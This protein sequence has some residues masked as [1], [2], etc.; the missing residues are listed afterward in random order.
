MSG[1]IGMHI[2]LLPN[3]IAI[4]NVGVLYIQKKK[5]TVPCI[6]FF[7]KTNEQLVSK[8]VVVPE[9]GRISVSSSCIELFKNS[10]PKRE[11]YFTFLAALDIKKSSIRSN[12]THKA[13]TV[14]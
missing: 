14:N 11:L 1:M 4:K 5:I 7:D 3:D 13:S 2:Q 9:P 12:Y 6:Y 10:S 8:C